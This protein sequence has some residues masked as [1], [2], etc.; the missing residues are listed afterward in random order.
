VQILLSV[1]N[2]DLPC[3]DR[4]L[5]HNAVSPPTMSVLMRRRSHDPNPMSSYAA[6]T[7]NSPIKPCLLD[8]WF[9]LNVVSTH[10]IGFFNLWVLL[11]VLSLQVHKTQLGITDPFAHGASDLPTRFDVLMLHRAGS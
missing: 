1:L 7:I 10:H 9:N 2:H 6:A 11:G 8:I 4:S 5:L 3:V